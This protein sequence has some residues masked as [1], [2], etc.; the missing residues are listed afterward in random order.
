MRT[1]VYISIEGQGY[2]ALL[3]REPSLILDKSG[4]MNQPLEVLFEPMPDLPE[5]M[6]EM[7]LDTQSHKTFILRQVKLSRVQESKQ[8][9]ER[10]LAIFT[11]ES[12]EVS[13]DPP[14]P[15]TPY[16][17][18]SVRMRKGKLYAKPVV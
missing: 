18:S 12:Y 5:E 8:H 13:N 15:K 16:L 1:N 3:K 4:P 11:Y 2:T 9:I 17:P 14:M 10:K 6:P 7:V